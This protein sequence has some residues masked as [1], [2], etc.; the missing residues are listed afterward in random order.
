[1][2]APPPARPGPRAARQWPRASR[3]WSAAPVPLMLE[4]YTSEPNTFFLKPLIAL[5]EKRAAFTQRYF[6]AAGLEQFAPDFPGDVE[7]SLQLEREGPL[8]VHDGTIICSSF[9]MLEYIAEALPGPS[10]IP[11][12]AYDPYR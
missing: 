4:L 9:F 8:L 1:M 3:C 11:A 12:D 5:A 10:L 6:D 2:S 7:S